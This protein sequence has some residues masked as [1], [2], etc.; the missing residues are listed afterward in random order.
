MT[1]KTRCSRCKC[2]KLN[3]VFFYNGK[4]HKTCFNCSESR[5][6][7]KNKCQ[8]CG[9]QARYNYKGQE[10]GIFCLKHSKADMVDIKNPKCITCKE[11][12]PNFNYAGE[13]KALYCSVCALA[14]MVDIKNP[15][16]ITCKERSA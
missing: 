15:K 4:I 2:S 9:I 8:T 5:K 6:P 16:C 10:E 1:D 12:G 7:T 11:K 14:D 3:E 13:T